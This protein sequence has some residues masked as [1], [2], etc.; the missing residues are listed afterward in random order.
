MSSRQGRRKRG[1]RLTSKPTSVPAH[2]ARIIGYN[3]AP[4]SVLLDGATN[5][6]DYGWMRQIDRRRAFDQSLA[7]PLS[8]TPSGVW[9]AS[10]SIDTRSE[11]MPY[12]TC[13]FCHGSGKVA[14]SDGKEK[15]C[16]AC[17]GSGK[18]LVQK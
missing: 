15:Q 17:G 4:G 2:D 14:G 16:G 9:T 3:L 10:S 6:R 11:R 7:S 5:Q 13:H 18:L 1:R 8:C 12:V